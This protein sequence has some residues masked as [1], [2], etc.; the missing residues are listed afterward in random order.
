LTTVPSD[1]IRTIARHYA[2]SP[3]NTPI[4]SPDN[5][6]RRELNLIV[7]K[8][9]KANGALSKEDHSFR[10]LVQRQDMT[11]ADRTWANH[12]EMGDVVRYGRGSKSMGIEAGSYGTV[13][14]IDPS[15]NLLSIEIASGE[16]ATYDPRR[17]TGVSVYREVA[18]EFSVGNR[19]QFTAPDKQLGV[20]NRDL[21]AIDSI[22]PDGRIAARLDD[23]RLIALNTAEHRHFD[24]GYA[25]TSHRSQGIT[26]ERAL[27]NMDAN[28]HSEL[29]N[30]RAAYVSVSRASHNIQIYTN[31]AASLAEYVSHDVNKAS[32]IDFNRLMNPAVS[33]TVE[34]ASSKEA[35]QTGQALSV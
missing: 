7:R 28:V 2:E 23:D 31:S 16:I 30:S 32:A 3:A 35:L 20:A 27:V 10:F 18:H 26:A 14:A 17:L 24:H 34:P 33:E 9:L 12:Y 21:A 15:A 4:V 22:T 8:E 5:A 11:G 1:S 13:A 25:V 6:S 29:I 19:I